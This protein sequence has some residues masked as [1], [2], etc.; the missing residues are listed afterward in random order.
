VIS[1]SSNPP[2][3]DGSLEEWL[4]RQIG[5]NR[6]AFKNRTVLLDVG[7]YHGDFARGFLGLANSPF[8]EAILFEP[9]PENLKF[10]RQQLN[11]D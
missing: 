4:V 1:P 5:S 7:A 2:A 11:G 3:L 6:D 8:A 10:L 9:N